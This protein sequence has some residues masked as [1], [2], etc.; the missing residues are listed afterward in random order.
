MNYIDEKQSYLKKNRLAVNIMMLYM[1]DYE[2]LYQCLDFDNEHLLEDVEDIII[3]LI[4]LQGDNIHYCP[5][6]IS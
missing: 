4:D 3:D 5:L 1:E 6:T 2:F